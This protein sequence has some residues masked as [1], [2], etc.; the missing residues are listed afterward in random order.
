[1]PFPQMFSS[2]ALP[3]PLSNPPPIAILPPLPPPPAGYTVRRVK[4][5]N[6]IMSLMLETAWQNFYKP[7][8]C[9]K[10]CVCGGG[11]PL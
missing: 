7:N 2:H 8:V 3:P 10:V 11:Q 4:N 5:I 6:G 1:M 9:I